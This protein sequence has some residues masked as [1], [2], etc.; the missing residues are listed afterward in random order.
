MNQWSINSGTCQN[1][2]LVAIIYHSIQ[3]TSSLNII[4]NVMPFQSSGKRQFTPPTFLN[5]SLS[6][7]LKVKITERSISVEYFFWEC[8]AF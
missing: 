4:L 2:L 6:I 8:K 3:V 5:V 1:Y 7:K